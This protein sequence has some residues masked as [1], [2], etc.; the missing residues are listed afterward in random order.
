MPT[1]KGEFGARFDAGW[2]CDAVSLILTVL[3]V[4]TVFK[5][6]LIDQIKHTARAMESQNIFRSW[7]R[8]EHGTWQRG[9]KCSTDKAFEWLSVCA[10][11][12]YR[13]KVAIIAFPDG[14]T[15]S[16]LKWSRICT[17]RTIAKCSAMRTSTIRWNA[18]VFACVFS[19]CLICHLLKA[20]SVHLRQWHRHRRLRRLAARIWYRVGRICDSF[21]RTINQ[22]IAHLSRAWEARLEVDRQHP[23][24]KVQ[25][26]GLNERLMSLYSFPTASNSWIIFDSFR[27]IERQVEF[28]VKT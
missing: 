17:L 11:I 3:K 19:K 16:N 10:A 12:I 18:S 26:H 13:S 28:N 4:L 22:G 9:V 5:D 14:L 25:T 7:E 21:I 6:P 2:L 15:N 27:Q 20:L 23:N 24:V 8:A 1:I